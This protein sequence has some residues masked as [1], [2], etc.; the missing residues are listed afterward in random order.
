MVFLQVA[1][2]GVSFREPRP[3]P[4]SVLVFAFAHD[5]NSLPMLLHLFTHNQK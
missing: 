3:L 1:M 5:T 2:A 4:L